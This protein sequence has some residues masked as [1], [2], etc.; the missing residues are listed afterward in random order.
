[1]AFALHQF[2]QIDLGLVPGPGFQADQ[3]QGEA[4]IVVIGELLDQRGEF[5]LGV[6]QAILLHQQAGVSQAHA[7]VV[8]V[9][10]DAVLQQRQGFVAAFHALQ[11]ARAQQQRG[12]VVAAGG[13]AFQQVQGFLRAVVLLQ[14]QGLAEQ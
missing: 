13:A 8:R 2:I 6:V 7:L 10:L 12:D 14:E 5:R 4:Q 3:R 9:F 11:Q 1:M